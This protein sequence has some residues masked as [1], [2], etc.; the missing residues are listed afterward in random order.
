MLNQRDLLCIVYD[1]FLFCIICLCVYRCYIAPERFYNQITDRKF[2]DSETIVGGHDGQVTESMDVF[3]LGCVIAE[4]FLNGEYV[5]F[6]LPNLLAY[7]EGKYDPMFIL[8]RIADHDIRILIQHMIQLNPN[9]RWSVREYLEKFSGKE[10]EKP[11]IS[12]TTLPSSSSTTIPSSS[13][14]SSSTSSPSSL[15]HPNA[16][17]VPTNTNDYHTFPSYFHYL[18]R[19]F[20]RFLYTEYLDP[21][22]KLHTLKKYEYELIWQITGVD[23]E[24]DKQIIM[25]DAA[26][27]KSPAANEQ[28]WSKGDNNNNSNNHIHINDNESGGNDDEYYYRHTVHTSPI[29]SIS[30][31]SSSSSSSSTHTSSSSTTDTKPSLLAAQQQHNRLMDDLQRCYKYIEENTNKLSASVSHP[32]SNS[33]SSSSDTGTTFPVPS[34][35]S[36]AKASSNTPNST[37]SFNNNNH[38]L[39]NDPYLSDPSLDPILSL[40]IIP[41]PFVFNAPTTTT[42]SNNNDTTSPISA[43]SPSSSSSPSSYVDYW[44]EQYLLY[45]KDKNASP[46]YSTMK[47]RRQGLT[48]LLSLVCSSI[49]NVRLPLSK[50]VGL[51]L[52]FTY[53]YLFDQNDDETR[54]SRIIPYCVSFLADANNL[55][56]STACHILTAILQLVSS[57]PNASY[58]HLFQEYIFPNLNSFPFDADELIRVTYAQ[59]IAKLATSA[60]KFLDIAQYM[61]Q[62]SMRNTMMAA[63]MNNN[64]NINNNNNN[65]ITTPDT[66]STTTATPPPTNN[67]S[68]TMLTPILPFDQIYDRDV[69]QLQETVLKLIIDMLTSGGSKVKRALLQ[70]LTKLCI[71]LGRKRVNNELLPHLITVLND[72]DWQLRCAFFTHIVGLAVFV[73]RQAFQNFILPCIEQALF[74]SEEF[75]IQRSVASLTV[76]SQLSLCDTKNQLSAATKASPLLMHP[77]AWI[78]HE[79][80]KLLAHMAKTLG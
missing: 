2:Q 68:S 20:S 70:D 73:G 57:L 4:L 32:S 50:L 38:H 71:F 28:W 69:F 79:T 66:P 7:R 35:M 9:D 62:V 77:S 36:S 44:Y 45:Q 8:N 52:L 78:R 75:V 31:S 14:T 27:I 24:K 5:L 25:K 42:S 16:A 72:K 11:R 43:S 12:S 15:S 51:E 58:A 41:T 65:N 48:M 61:R 76:L 47:S 13:S 53:G 34:F 18:F 56:R 63:L 37:K 67:P 10:I 49:Q 59:N 40:S 54:L 39:S 80:I 21:D 55:V 19:L 74:D 22:T 30:A 33:S 26:F 6:D 46:N 64:N 17:I 29:P 1:V 3:S 23:L 60:K